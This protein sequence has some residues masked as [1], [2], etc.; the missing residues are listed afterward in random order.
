MLNVASS[1]KH[2]Q[3]TQDLLFTQRLGL[4]LRRMI[5]EFTSTL[6]TCSLSDS[7][8]PRPPS[9]QTA[10]WMPQCASEKPAILDLYIPPPLGSSYSPG[11]PAHWCARLLGLEICW[12]WEDH[13]H[14]KRRAASRIHCQKARPGVSGLWNG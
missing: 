5:L 10:R 13:E 4:V 9:P 8:P 11:G 6:Y 3:M 1:C 12:W 2:V 14:L 7:V